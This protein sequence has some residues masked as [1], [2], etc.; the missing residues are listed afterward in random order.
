MQPAATKDK[1]KGKGKGNTQCKADAL[2][3]SPMC[4]EMILSCGQAGMAFNHILTATN[5]AFLTS[6]SG[7]LALAVLWLDMR[8]LIRICDFHTTGPSYAAAESYVLRLEEPSS[9]LGDMNAVPVWNEFCNAGRDI[10]AGLS[11]FG[12]SAH[13]TYSDQWGKAYGIQPKDDMTNIPPRFNSSGEIIKKRKL[14][15]SFGVS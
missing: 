10:P 5:I 2:F 11:A 12:V 6:E 3:T 4:V 9:A 8:T 13:K 7:G 15:W 1:G 14:F